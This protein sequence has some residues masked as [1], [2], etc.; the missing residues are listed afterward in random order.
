M[1]KGIEKINPQAIKASSAGMKV[2]ASKDF[3]SF[4]G[5]VNAMGPAAV[6]AG[7]MYAK[8][9]AQAVLQAA[10]SG[11]AQSGSVGGSTPYMASGTV[12][13]MMG[14]GSYAGMKGTS[15]PGGTDPVGADAGVD[16][17]TLMNT[18]YQNNLKLL[19]LQAIMQ[20]NM[21]AWNTKSNILSADHRARMAMIEKFS[22]R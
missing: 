18:M 11:A 14:A 21:Q 16:Q 7:D 10:F 15:V 22:T 13:G 5:A 19:E 9:P 3:S 17:A 12:P 8:V 1:N 20:T 2:G 6:T 4:I